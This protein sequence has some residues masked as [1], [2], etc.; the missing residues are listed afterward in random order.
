MRKF[1][2]NVATENWKG[3]NVLTRLMRAMSADNRE[4]GVISIDQSM[5][6]LRTKQSQHFGDESGH[7]WDWKYTTIDG[8]QTASIVTRQQRWWRSRRREGEAKAFD[9]NKAIECRAVSPH[10]LKG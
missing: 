10:Q 5:N 7:D 3:V 6:Y 1:V 8:R 4:N 9:E 2:E